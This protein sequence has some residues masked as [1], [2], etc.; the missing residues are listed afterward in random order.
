MESREIKE[1]YKNFSI[2]N[3][4]ENAFDHPAPIFWSTV[5]TADQVRLL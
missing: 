5:I 3:I 4:C 2:F 1:I